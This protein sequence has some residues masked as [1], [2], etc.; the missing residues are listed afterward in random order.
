MSSARPKVLY[1]VHRVPYPPDKGDRIRSYHLLRYLARRADVHLACLADEPVSAATF[2][3]LQRLCD[4][5]AVVHL[6]G[7]SRWLRAAGSLLWGGCLSEG[8]FHSP[9]LVRQLR[10]W[11]NDTKYHVVLASASSVA[12]Y[13]RIGE[14]ADVP[15]VVDLVDVDS[16]KW[17]DYAAAGRGWRAWVHG[18]E[19]RRLR[20]RERWLAGWARAVSVVS[21]HEAELCRGC[22]PSARVHVVPNGV[23]TEYFVPVES[24]VDEQGC[25][26]VGALDYPPNIDAACWFTREVWPAIHARHREARLR[27]VGRKPVRAVRALR[28][29]SGVDVVGGVADVRPHV[30]PAAVAVAPLRL[31]RGVQNKVLEAMAMGRP[32]VASPAA[33]AGLGHRPGLPVVS[34]QAAQ[35]W[36]DV[37]DELLPDVLRRRELGSAGRRYVLRHHD[38]DRCLNPF[39]ELL[40]LGS[41]EANPAYR[42]A[43]VA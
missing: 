10:S 19:G 28:S 20:K 39:A 18:L 14:F 34:A 22:A 37:L 8:A 41:G 15:A 1:V 17:L 25:V 9:A 5:V 21:E 43:T 3:Q 7:W 16:Q 4:R 32:V 2:A 35:E 33:L 36:I 12:A 23:D 38:W 30:A 26:F 42:A 27:L 6:G 11:A 40:G 29:V 13:L 24:T 31:A